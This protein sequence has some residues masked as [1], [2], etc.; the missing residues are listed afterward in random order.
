MSRIEDYHRANQTATY[1]RE[2]Y[3]KSTGQDSP[4]NDKHRIECKFLELAKTDWHPALLSFH[5]SHGYYGSSSCY[6]DMSES[7]GR[8]V[9]QAI[10]EMG[11][12]IMRRAAEL[13]DKDAERTRKTAEDEA[14]AVLLE[15]DAGVGR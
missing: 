8:Y 3:L 11:A 4:Q 6:S 2:V 12:T 14:R 15:L 7:V 13:A 5:A 1:L 10:T 9:A